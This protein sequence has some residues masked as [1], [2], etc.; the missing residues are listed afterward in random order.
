MSKYFPELDY[1]F[2]S[3][4]ETWGEITIE[5]VNV[6]ETLELTNIASNSVFELLFRD[7][8][9][10][11]VIYT[12]M[13]TPSITTLPKKILDR[14]SIKR[15]KPQIYIST[16]EDLGIFTVTAEEVLGLTVDDVYMLEHLYS[17][18]K[19]LPSGDWVN[20]V[21]A[22]NPQ[23]NLSKMI[24]L[25]I[26]MRVEQNFDYINNLDNILTTPF[27]NTLEYLYF[28]YLI[29][30]THRFLKINKIMVESSP[31]RLI[32]VRT[33]YTITQDD[34]TAGYFVLSNPAPYPDTDVYVYHNGLLWN[35][36]EYEIQYSMDSTSTANVIWNSE[37]V[38]VENKDYTVIDYY[39]DALANPEGTS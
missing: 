34:I 16:S 29:N 36:D 1:W 25:Y 9:N 14:L 32:P 19:G 38:L 27:E 28:L 18:K 17:F 21:S 11:D 4:W 6:P 5:H 35:T 13:R 10:Y 30:E 24:Q 37:K 22:Y 7:V 33:A 12:K 31:I 2:K 8:Y 39:T 3:Y 26:L 23:T 15:D 20:D